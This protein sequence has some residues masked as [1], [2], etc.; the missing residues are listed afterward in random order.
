MKNKTLTN[1]FLEKLHFWT[2]PTS[3]QNN[4]KSCKQI[5]IVTHIPKGIPIGKE[6]S[7]SFFK[8]E[9]SSYEYLVQVDIEVISPLFFVTKTIY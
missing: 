1:D 8:D 4:S 6:V 7:L 9:S 3:I 5:A 2:V